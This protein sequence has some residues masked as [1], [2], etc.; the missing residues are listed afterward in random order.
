MAQFQTSTQPLC[1][2]RRQTLKMAVEPTDRLTEEVRPIRMLR[3]VSAET[4]SASGQSDQP[5]I[6][7]HFAHCRFH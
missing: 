4:V 2:W 7:S 5:H 1:G 6:D 3:G